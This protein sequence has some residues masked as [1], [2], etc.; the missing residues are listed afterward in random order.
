M[1]HLIA[2][3]FIT[4]NLT[5]CGSGSSDSSS[6]AGSRNS[7]AT[8]AELATMASATPL[9]L[10]NPPATRADRDRPDDFS[11][12][13]VHLIYAVPAGGTDNRLDVSGTLSNSLG[14]MN[15]WLAA[16]TGGRWIRFD[17]AGG[18]PDVTFVQLPGTDAYYELS[19]AHKRDAIEAELKKLDKLSPEKIYAV[20]YEGGNPRACADAPHPPALPG[21]VTVWYLQGLSSGPWPCAGNPFAASQTAQPGYREFSLLHELLHTFGAVGP[22]GP[23]YFNTHVNHDARD[24]MYAGPQPWRPGILD[25]GRSNYY[26][27]AGRPWRVRAGRRAMAAR[28]TG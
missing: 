24:I 23:N 14:S 6:L 10:G 18:A 19:G 4:F 12:S 7:Q 17:T 9:P 22:G 26:S 8:Q 25:V 16:Q 1:R 20:F 27:P 11:G 3:L 5:A 2:L 21:Q 28:P 15:N 13:Q